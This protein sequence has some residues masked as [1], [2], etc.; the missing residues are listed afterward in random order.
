MKKSNK[1][2]I[3]ISL[4]I[5]SLVFAGIVSASYGISSPYWKGHPLQIAPGDTRT[6]SITLQNMEEEDIKVKVILKKGSEIASIEEGE[7]TIPSKTKDTEILVKIQIPEEVEFGTEYLVTL[8]SSE[9][10]SG[11]TGG[12]SLGVSME[13]S[14]DVV[15][16][17]VTKTQEEKNYSWIIILSIAIVILAILIIFAKK[18]SKK[19]RKK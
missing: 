17:D 14:F 5:F 4:L 18:K 15:V 3:G 7:Y 19:S 1:L 13:T 6:V 10:I 8:S 11:D 9:V 2:K 16:A 12:V